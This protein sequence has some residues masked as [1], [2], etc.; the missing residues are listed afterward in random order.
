MYATPTGALRR[1]AP[2]DAARQVAM[3]ARHHFSGTLIV[4]E[5]EGTAVD[6]ESHLEMQVALVMLARRDVVHLETQVPCPWVDAAG[7]ARTHYFDFRLMLRDGSRV[8]L[9][10]KP[11]KTARTARFR[12]TAA[13]IAAQ[14][15]P[16]IAD[17]VCVMTDRHVDPIDLHNAELLH[18]CR[19]PDPEVDAAARR[20][21][22]GLRGAARIGDLVAALD[23][24]GRGFR[25][26]ARLLRS[27][28]LD[29]VR[30]ERITPEAHVT[31]RTA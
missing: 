11:A 13:R 21:I 3:G 28:D 4:G 2:P 7:H 15:T 29:L 25:A 9:I 30:H 19:T 24:G 20:M 18:G 10:V 6:V 23:R 8:A 26:V 31:R 17:R 27:H 14:V 22:G 5:D 1:P 12:E 16:D